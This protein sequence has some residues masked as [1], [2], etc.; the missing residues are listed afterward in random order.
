VADVLTDIAGMP[1]PAPSVGTVAAE[2][3]T[4]AA[5]YYPLGRSEGTAKMM[6][7]RMPDLVKGAGFVGPG[8]NKPLDNYSEISQ[9]GAEAM[10]SLRTETWSGF[11]NKAATVNSLNQNWLNGYG[12]FKTA[13]NQM[14]PV[15]YI[16]AIVKN[17][18]GGGEAIS[19][20]Y[21]SFTAGNL[22]LPGTV[23]GLTPFNLLAP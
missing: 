20:A 6:A 8:A 19:A 2:A 1:A 4:Q 21:K 14:S 13:L 7:G 16:N 3:E 23:S 22:G 10:I 12:A 11:N 5:Q 17:L 18:P 15:D 9:R